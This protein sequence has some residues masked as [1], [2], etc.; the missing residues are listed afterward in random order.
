MKLCIMLLK[1]HSHIPLLLLIG[2]IL[3]M[4]V[5]SANAAN[6]CANVNGSDSPIHIVNM[7]LNTDKPLVPGQVAYESRMYS[8]QYQCHADAGVTG[9][10]PGFG[11]GDA[12]DLNMILN[13]AGLELKIIVNGRTFSG[14]DFN[15]THIPFDSELSPGET[16]HSTA[17]IKLQLVAT[18]NITGVVKVS[19]PSARAFIITPGFGS[20]WADVNFTAFNLQSIP[21]CFG[22]VRIMP[23]VISFGHI[24]TD[25]PSSGSSPLRQAA[26][27]ITADRNPACAGITSDRYD[28][29]LIS[30]FSVA[31]KSLT[32]NN[33]SIVLT[34]SAG[35][36]GLTLSL[37]D[38][39]GG[40]LQFGTPS[41][42][43]DIS[44]RTGTIIQRKYTALLE[45]IAGQPLQ[46]GAFTAD[47]V[48]KITY[49]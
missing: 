29:S 16:R 28:I 48:V 32:N 1:S 9:L 41:F 39:T 27:T 11:R 46:T 37:Q 13:R 40:R 36:N 23:S 24:Y 3:V 4:S 21:S 47:V 19:I 30:Q 18:K 35:A 12:P 49:E 31:G 17:N 26:F 45:K 42:F 43:G 6:Y 14:N 10:A 33:Q 7:T 2:F 44:S 22:R 25:D 5:S 8:V 20:T 34:N 15:A 38:D